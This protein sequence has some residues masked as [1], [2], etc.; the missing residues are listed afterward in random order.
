MATEKE[1]AI[2][3]ITI[4]QSD[5]FTEL[6]KLKKSILQTKQEQAELNKAFKAGNITQDEY[7]KELVRTEAL[8]KRQQSSY[9]NVQ[10][11]VTGVKTQLDKLIDSNQKISKS[12]DQ[13]ASK[14]DKLGSDFKAASA[15]INVAGVSVGD[16]TGKLAGFANPATAAVGIISAL[17]AAYARSTVGAKDLEFAQNQLN[18]AI[19]IGT[20]A[21]ANLITSSED[22]EGLFS[23]ITSAIL[24]R[25][26][27]TTAVL[28]KL[29]AQNQE[30]LEDLQREEIEIRGQISDRLADNQEKLTQI[31]DA[32]TSVNDKLRLGNE[33]LSN[34]EKN[35]SQLTAVLQQ[36]LA[37]LKDQLA[38]D[39]QNEDIQTAILQKQREINKLN[40]DTEKRIQGQRRANDNILQ[41]EQERIRLAKELEREAGKSGLSSSIRPEREAEDKNNAVSFFKDQANVTVDVQKG[42]NNA[43]DAL[44]RQRTQAATQQAGER[45]RLEKQSQQDQLD[46]LAN[47]ASQAAA[48]FEQDSAAYKVLATADAIINTYKGANLA[49]GTIPPPLSY[50]AAAVT[51]A[52]GLANVAQINGAGFAEGGYTGDGGKY[53]PAG[54]VHRGEYV[55]PKHIVHNP[56]Y[57]GHIEALERVRTRGYADGGLV[58]NDLTREANQ[59]LIMANTMKNLPTPEVS[60]NEI[61][62]VQNRIRVKE[63]VAKTGK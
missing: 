41:Q 50:V 39:N 43:L 24:F 3:T 10:K 30:K 15:N 46:V 27:A 17:G 12:F 28:A 6:E 36:E 22:G 53:E 13:T 29:A 52:A 18:F 5:A 54:V 9:N 25:I 48:I 31:A 61:S 8:L 2:L 49:L 51:I 4:E 63:R 45:F 26:D 42:L 21:F 1:E 33:I 40:A 56:K 14:L 19:T 37:I 7:A 47:T 23:K 35:R 38:I 16:V 20:N 34:F 11:S 32:Q 59:S 55:V 44:D 60:V 62:K 58:T 57:T